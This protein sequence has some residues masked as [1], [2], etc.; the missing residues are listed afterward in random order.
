[1]S[2]DGDLVIIGAG[3]FGLEVLLYAREARERGW[4]HTV[5]GFIDDVVPVGTVVDDGLQVLG[6]SDDGALLSGGAIIAVGD[7]DIRSS[8][9][10]KVES[11]G[12]ELV[13]LT[14]HTAYV[15]RSATVGPGSIL[16]P[17]AMV[18]AHAVVG[19]NVSINVYASVGHE[20]V[21]GDHVV[22]SPYSALLGRTHLGVRCYVGTNA[23]VAPGVSVGRQSKMSVGAAVMRDAPAGSLLVGNPAK[24]RV[25]FRVDDR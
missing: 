3:G 21:V 2:R 23:T 10:T 8:L 6:T 9:A 7:A 20:A 25:M 1:V 16:C 17:F 24:G 15:A 12:G 22:L 4:P 13:T 11:S 14:H 18:A 19:R 5:A